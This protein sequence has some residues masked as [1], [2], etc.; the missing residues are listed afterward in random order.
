[1]T[2]RTRANRVYCPGF[3]INQDGT[4][5]VLVGTD[6]GIVNGDTFQLQVISSLVK[7]ILIDAMLVGNNFPEFGTCKN[8]SIVST[9]EELG[10]LDEEGAY[11]FGYRTKVVSTTSNMIL[12]ENIPDQ[13]GCEQFHACLGSVVG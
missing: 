6:L 13:F 12:M 4:R 10:V 1:M 5:N 3:K 9:S 2:N 7:A 11:Q 8:E